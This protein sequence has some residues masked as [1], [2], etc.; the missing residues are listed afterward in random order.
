MSFDVAKWNKKRYLAEAGIVG[1]KSAYDQYLDIV[2]DYLR[3]ANGADAADYLERMRN[4][5]TNT[6]SKVQEGQTVH[7]GNY[8]MEESEGNL[9]DMF[10]KEFGTRAYS[11]KDSLTI[12]ASEDLS[13]ETFEKMIK[14]VEDKGYK[15]DRAKSTNWYDDDGEKKVFPK[16][17]FSK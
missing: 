2:I 1:D 17:V 8:D 15:V 12:R 5:I 6:M 16:I 4:F 11:D 10:A 3:E 14:F 13:D 9:G 7:E